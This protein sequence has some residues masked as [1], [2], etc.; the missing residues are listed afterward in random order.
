M[1]FPETAADV[2]QIV[3]R[4]CS[5]QARIVVQWHNNLPGKDVVEQYLQTNNLNVRLASNIKRSRAAIGE[6]DAVEI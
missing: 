6:A 1:K 2:R 5:K 3:Q 4:Y